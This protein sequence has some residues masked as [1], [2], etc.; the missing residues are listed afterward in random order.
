MTRNEDDKPSGLG[1]K[2]TDFNGKNWKKF[3]TQIDLYLFTNC[4][5][6]KTDDDK[7]ACVLSFMK[8]DKAPTWAEYKIDQAFEDRV[9]GECCSTP[10]FGTFA[11]FLK[12]LSTDHGH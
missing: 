11:Q 8:Y 3:R 2:P 10:T 12:E 9:T 7:I 1:G 4:E 6:I 5:K